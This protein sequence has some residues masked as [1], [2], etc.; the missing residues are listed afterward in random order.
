[1]DK[2]RRG[3]IF[4][5]GL[6]LL[7]LQ[8]ANSLEITNLRVPSSYTI[9]R[10]ENQEKDLVLG[11]D[12]DIDENDSKGFVL[13]WKHNDLQIYQWIPS[14]N[15]VVFSSF[16]GHL[17]TEYSESEDRLHKHSALKFITP[18]ANHTGNYTCQ[19]STYQRMATKTAHL[20]IIV[21]ET[22]FSLGFQRETNGSTLVFCNVGEIYP[23][24]DVS[25]VIDD[26]KVTDV[27]VSEQVQDFTGYYNVSVQHILADQNKD[28]QIDC[29]VTIPATEYRLHTSMPYLGSGL[30]VTGAT[31][32]VVLCTLVTTVVAR[33]LCA[34]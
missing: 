30:Q 14:R 26:E 20:Q 8:V 13:K 2:Q 18:M 23:L 17:D 6:V 29:E 15:P 4:K 27:V 34:F 11:C 19:V 5:T 9:A 3:L 33:M 32:P 7:F 25:L 31:L 22:D 1:M 16:R 10:A 21:P 28:M 24:P 12:Y